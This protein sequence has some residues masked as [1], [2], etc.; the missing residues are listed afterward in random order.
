MYRPTDPVTKYHLLAPPVL[1]GRR[2]Q[3]AQVVESLVLGQTRE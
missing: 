3:L 2:P 1:L